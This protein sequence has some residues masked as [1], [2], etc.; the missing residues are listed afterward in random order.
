M[1]NALDLLKM[2]AA[3][4]GQVVHNK[5]KLREPG[6][7][8]PVPGRSCGDCTMCCKLYAVPVMN[9]P[10]NIWCRECKPGKGCGIWETRPQ[11]CRDFH[12][13]YILDADVGE[14]WRP[15]ISKFIM[16]FQ[17]SNAL[18]VRV[19]SSDKSA[20]KREPYYSTFKRWAPDFIAAGGHIL[21]SDGVHVYCVL[22]HEDFL[23]CRYGEKVDFHIETAKVG[24]TTVNRVVLRNGTFVGNEKTAGL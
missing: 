8:K 24:L 20:W 7:R 10:E 5:P 13:H 9:K 2:P 14:D 6:E 19:D 22:P 17:S 15:N 18:W 11:F 1:S 12:C 21:V 4:M 3:P 23:L 16:N